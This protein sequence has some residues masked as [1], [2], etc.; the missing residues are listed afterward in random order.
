MVSKESSINF[1]VIGAGRM[2]RIHIDAGQRCGFNLVGVSDLRAEALQ[3]IQEKYGLSPSRAFLNNLDLLNQVDFDLAIVA[4]TAPS[5]FKIVKALSTTKVKF[6]L[7]EKPISNSIRHAQD[8]IELC[9]EKNIGLAINHQMRYMEQYSMIKNAHS[10]FSVGDLKSMVVSGSNV[11]L[12]MNGTHYFEA[13][14]WLTDNPITSVWAWLDES[15]TNNPR[16]PEFFDQSGQIFATNILGQR[17]YLEIGS[18]L[19]HEIIV[20]YNYEFGKIVVN[21]LSGMVHVNSRL[22]EDLKLPKTRYGLLG[23]R[24]FFNIERADTL[25]STVEVLLSLINGNDYPTGEN[26]LHAIEVAFAAIMSSEN[27][28]SEIK[29]SDVHKNVI[30]QKW[31]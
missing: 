1:I 27:G 14:R 9:R 26:A 11:G 5:H 19:G 13:F 22:L 2:G 29:L 31:A 24:E 6:I 20:V 8:M 23:N 4:T 3:D 7:C 21:E 10:R 12:A 16:G 28:N 30:L 17:L 15:E 18:D 25:N